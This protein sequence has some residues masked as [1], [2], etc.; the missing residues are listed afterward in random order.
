MKI[1]LLGRDGQVGWQLQRSLAPHGDVLAL[2][3]NDCDLADRK[4]VRA[5]L[6][7]CTPSLIVNAASARPEASPEAWRQINVDLP[8]LLASEACRTGALLVHYSC[9]TVFSYEQREARDE[10]DT[11]TPA[12]AYG[13]SKLEGE[14][15]VREAG[16]RSLIFRLGWVFGARGES[17][18]KEVLRE[19]RERDEWA[20]CDGV[21][22]SPTPAALVSTVTGVVLAALRQGRALS[23]GESRLYHLAGKE[24][25]TRLAFARAVLASARE[26]PGFD[27]RLTEGG[28]FPT[29]DSGAGG[30]CGAVLS[31]NRLEADFGLAMPSWRPYLERMLQLLAVKRNG[32]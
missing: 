25:V 26:I 9:D 18:V 15:A 5:Y 6:R 10:S 22:G 27:L 32:Y 8:G 2:A 3:R 21:L 11:P 19:A 16:C 29:R 20:L 12:S 23:A 17:I 4:K 13:L 30:R 7:D 14:Y 31:C 24:A 28:L 1:L